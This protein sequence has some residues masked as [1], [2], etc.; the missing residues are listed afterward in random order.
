MAAA[1]IGARTYA[2]DQCRTAETKRLAANKAVQNRSEMAEDAAMEE[3]RD[4]HGRL[5]GEAHTSGR[6]RGAD[7]LD[8][9]EAASSLFALQQVL[10]RDDAPATT[11]ALRALTNGIRARDANAKQTCAEW[12]RSSPRLAELFHAYSAPGGRD[13]DSKTAACFRTLA[14]MLPLL[15]KQ[16]AISCWALA[17]KTWGLVRA[18]RSSRHKDSRRAALEALEKGALC[19]TGS[20]QVLRWLGE[21]EKTWLSLCSARGKEGTRTKCARVMSA[22]ARSGTKD[23]R[24]DACKLLLPALLKGLEEDAPRDVHLLLTAL[25]PERDDVHVVTALS[26]VDGAKALRIVA[27]YLRSSRKDLS[28]IHI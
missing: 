5:I 3:A 15:P 21:D 10:Q 25:R 6:L 2:R 17:A 7:M 18:L 19:G 4:E 1:A 27:A 14:T 26:S 13:A 20:Q 9:S 16:D 22:V 8:A 28:L 11:K 12:A 23:E 24:R